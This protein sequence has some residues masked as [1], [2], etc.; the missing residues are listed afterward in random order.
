MQ[1]RNQ[2]VLDIV[3]SII[4]SK[5]PK[6]HI[7][8]I[9]TTFELPE[10]KEITITLHS[11]PQNLK[12]KVVCVVISR[13]RGLASNAPYGEEYDHVR[14]TVQALK[15][16]E[17]GEAK[18]VVPDTLGRF[19]FDARI[20]TVPVRRN[21]HPDSK[22]WE[23]SDINQIKILSN[24]EIVELFAALPTNPQ[25]Q[26][27]LQENKE[28]NNELAVDLLGEMFRLSSKAGGKK[29]IDGIKPIWDT[30]KENGEDKRVTIQDWDQT[31]NE[32]TVLDSK[33]SQRKAFSDALKDLENLYNSSTA[34]GLMCKEAV[35]AASLDILQNKKYHD[36]GIRLNS[37]IADVR[38]ISIFNNPSLE[39]LNKFI[40]TADFDQLGLI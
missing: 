22:P 34:L 35:D 5:K 2:P 10:K 19:N 17:F 16:V 7:K 32:I 3:P 21:E 29:Y 4:P 11:T 15:E 18:F 13:P 23:I 28:L 8:Y 27:M 26:K 33:T 20:V 9:K 31:L 38:Y 1:P 24:D 25:C 14:V 37:I 36:A 40:K 6:Q 30:L 39:K 12:D